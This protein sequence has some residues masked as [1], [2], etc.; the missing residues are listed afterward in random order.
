MD[1]SVKALMFVCVS[2]PT[3]ID[4]IVYLVTTLLA[5]LMILGK[6]TAVAPPRVGKVTF[7]LPSLP[8]RLITPVD[9]AMLALGICGPI[10]EVTP[11]MLKPVAV[12][13]IVV[14]IWL[15]LCFN[16]T[17]KSLLTPLNSVWLFEEYKKSRLPFTDTLEPDKV[18]LLLSV[19]VTSGNV[20]VLLIE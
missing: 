15:N 5:A 12:A 10:T 20:D 11:V 7:T 3:V 2:G 9:N 14:V 13:S 16:T 17:F 18:L 19:N 1:R 4:P 8:L 6:P